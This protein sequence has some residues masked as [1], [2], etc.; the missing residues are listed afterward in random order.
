MA[1]LTN[2]T[3]DNSMKTLSDLRCKAEFTGKAHSELIFLSVL[4]TFLS[5]TAIL[6]NTLILVAL[7]KDTSLHPPSKLLFRNLAITDLF[8]GITAEPLFVV[9]LMSVVRERWDVCFYVLVSGLSASYILCS[10]SFLTMTAISVD[11]L[12]ALSLRLRYRQVVTFK[13]TCTALCLFITF[14]AYTKIFF[15]LRHNRLHFQAP[16]FQR[17]PNQ[18]IPMNIAR[19]RKAVYSAL[20][21]Q[22]TLVV[23]YLPAAIVVALTPQRGI[24]TSTYLN[25]QFTISLVFLNSSLNPLL[26]YWKIREVRQAVKEILRGLRCSSN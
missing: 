4:N 12:L 16:T 18:A 17:Q 21:V 8:V 3:E 25:K 10:V 19:Y 6:E 2:F 7:H 15:I 20:W 26:Y 5:I 23:C 14:F 1:E 24:P 13:R 11:R 22:G 9:Y